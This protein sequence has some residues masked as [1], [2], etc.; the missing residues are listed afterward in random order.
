MN[1]TIQ[2]YHHGAEIVK[3]NLNG[4]WLCRVLKGSIQV[5]FE[6]KTLKL[7][8]GTVFAVQEG[9]AFRVKSSTRNM[10]VEVMAFDESLMNVSYMLWLGRRPTSGRWKRPFG[11]TQRWMSHLAECL[12]LIM[13]CF[14]W[15]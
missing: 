14:G 8:A 9:A 7:V 13:S 1:I 10:V 15:Q 11:A 3:S 4:L 5:L 12:L 2:Q 6:Q